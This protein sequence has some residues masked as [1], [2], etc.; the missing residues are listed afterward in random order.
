MPRVKNTR[1]SKN[2]GTKAFVEM[3][4]SIVSVLHPVFC[5]NGEEERVLVR[6]RDSLIRSADSGGG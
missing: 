5:G 2:I 1:V 6:K 4:T 3:L